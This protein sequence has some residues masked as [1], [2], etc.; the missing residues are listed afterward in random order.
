MRLIEKSTWSAHQ[1]KCHAMPEEVAD[2]ERRIRRGMRLVPELLAKNKK[3]KGIPTILGRATLVAGGVF[4]G[5]A[6][7]RL[8]RE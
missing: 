6:G 8:W 4:L 3:T 5:W 2:E 7:S 1:S